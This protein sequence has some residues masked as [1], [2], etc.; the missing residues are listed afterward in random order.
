MGI[1]D[2]GIDGTITSPLGAASEVEDTIV[3]GVVYKAPSQ[4]AVFDALAGKADSLGFTPAKD[5]LS[6]LGSTAIN[7]N[8]VF[9]TGSEA[10]IKTKDAAGNTKNLVIQSGA[11]G[12]S[13]GGVY[14]KSGN[15]PA[16][17]VPAGSILIGNSVRPEA[18]QIDAN[19]SA[20]LTLSNKYA[21]FGESAPSTE[22]EI[23]AEKITLSGY[24]NGGPN[25]MATL[26]MFDA[27]YDKYVAIR[28]P[29]SV[30][31]NITF[32]LPG[33]DGTASQVIKTNGSGVL[34]FGNPYSYT[35]EDANNKGAVSGYC[36][37][38]S[39]QKVPVGNLPN[40]IMEYKG[41]F[42]PATATFTDA[43]GNAGDVYWAT[44]A[45][46]YDAGSGNITYVIGDWAVHNGTIFQKSLNSNTTAGASVALD[47]LTTTAVNAD[48][49][50][51]GPATVILENDVA[52][53]GLD[54]SVV[55]K[56]L[57]RMDASDIL[58][59]GDDWS[60]YSLLVQD[61]SIDA[62]TNAARNGT[63]SVG[64]KEITINPTG[65]S[66]Q[67]NFGS[68][69]GGAVSIKAP[70]SATGVLFTLP[71]ADGTAGQVL[72]TDGAGVLSWVSHVVP[73]GITIGDGS[74]AITTG[75]KGYITVPFACTIQSWR[76]IADQSGS[77]VVDVKRATYSAFPTMGSI[78]GTELPTLS[79]AQKNED[80]TLSTWT[81]SLAAGDIIEFVVN[82]AT[83]VTRVN[84]SIKAVRT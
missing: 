56:N 45:G 70:D 20:G 18:L 46:T 53:K 7:S 68:Y 21:Y 1:F 4:N 48:L 61:G 80:T 34:S 30:A 31:A 84:L 11:S 75:T 24:S 57:I 17:T 3:D 8:L 42:D 69:L 76:V 6:N 39:G 38:D 35:P 16:Y 47:N 78:A 12:A 63:F 28:P 49:N 37:L 50:M 27:N 9:D 58:T 15:T 64:G 32:Q 51:V 23:S 14:I 60:T 10:I 41:A 65:V 66:A 19:A 71:G 73:I 81:T 36:P 5:D 77:I 25:D 40:S 54:T 44:A 74:V 55:P 62:N 82:S 2:R 67:L 22:V 72:K 29:Q 43:S 79:T 52:L 83:T 59:V 26:R 33:A 13:P